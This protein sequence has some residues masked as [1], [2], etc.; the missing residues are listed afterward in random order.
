MTRS[1][2][3]KKAARRLLFKVKPSARLRE[4]GFRELPVNQLV[5]ESFHKLGAGIPVIDVVGML[6]YIN[7]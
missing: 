7:G 4:V 3:T 5:Q 1:I 6:P 2:D